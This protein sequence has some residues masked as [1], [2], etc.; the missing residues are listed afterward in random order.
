ME[1]K[2]NKYEKKCIN[3]KT[4]GILKSIFKEKCRK[5]FVSEKNS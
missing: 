3:L 2:K 4:K 5:L 1:E